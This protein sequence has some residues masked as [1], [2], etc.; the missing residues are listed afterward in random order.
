[1][2]PKISA[3]GHY[4]AEHLRECVEEARQMASALRD[5]EAK[6]TMLRVAEMYERMAA[7]A[8]AREEAKRRG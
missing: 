4:S 7:S 3:D 5:P 6:Q 1:M 2:K 8:A